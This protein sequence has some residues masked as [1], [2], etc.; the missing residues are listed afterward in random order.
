M[1]KFFAKTQEGA[2]VY[3]QILLLEHAPD[4]QTWEDKLW[5]RRIDLKLLH[6]HWEEWKATT[7]RIRLL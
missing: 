1:L 3:I 4:A 7:A 6:S 2:R 5:D